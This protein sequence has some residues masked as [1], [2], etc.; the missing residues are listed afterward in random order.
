MKKSILVLC[1][2]AFL[3][4]G[5]NKVTTVE[6]PAA[7]SSRHLTVDINVNFAADTRSVKTGW[8]AGDVIYVAFDDWFPIRRIT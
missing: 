6:E 5:C 8:E 4:S 3:A 7:D 2:L 1:S